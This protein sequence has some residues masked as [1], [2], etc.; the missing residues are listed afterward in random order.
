[1]NLLKKKT[2]LE[3]SFGQ[4]DEFE[5]HMRLEVVGSRNLSESGS[6]WVSRL[7][8]FWGRLVDPGKG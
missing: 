7:N 8:F 6:L 4:R 3:T 2:S 5:K 1:M